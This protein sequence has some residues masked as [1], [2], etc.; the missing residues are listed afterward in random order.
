MDGWIFNRP[1]TSVWNKQKWKYSR[2]I[3]YISMNYIMTC[4]SIRTYIFQP[5]LNFSVHKICS[6]V[7]KHLFELFPIHNGLENTYFCHRFSTL[8]CKMTF[9]RIKTAGL[10][11]ISKNQILVYADVN[12]SSENK[13][14]ETVPFRC[15]KEV[16]LK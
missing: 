12:I 7:C 9:R 16:N 5:I 15:R 3:Y 10:K 4:D 11:F 1:S 13:V 8:L 2:R 14:Q 6:L